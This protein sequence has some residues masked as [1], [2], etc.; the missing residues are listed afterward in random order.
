MKISLYFYRFQVDEVSN[1][2]LKLATNHRF[3]EET[4]EGFIIDSRE[5][6]DVRLRYVFKETI[7]ENLEDPFGERISVDRVRYD[8]SRLRVRAEEDVIEVAQPG[9]KIGKCLS[10]LSDNLQGAPTKLVPNF[11]HLFESLSRL[12]GEFTV[13]ALETNSF[14]IKSRTACRVS[15]RALVDV[16]D[17][18]DYFLS[19]RSFQIKMARLKLFIRNEPVL[20]DVFDTGRIVAYFDPFLDVY[21][22]LMKPLISS[23]Y[24][25]KD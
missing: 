6:N 5:M 15:F 21:D 12:E 10:L 4:E 18:V 8:I 19:K 1:V 9:R 17:D 13:L 25:V 11:V 22:T 20:I 16:R 3:S 24:I 2:L 23:L 7:S 14:T